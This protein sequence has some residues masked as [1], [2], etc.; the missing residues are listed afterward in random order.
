MLIYKR[1]SRRLP[2]SLIFFNEKLSQEILSLPHRTFGRGHWSHTFHV[3]YI[4]L[5]QNHLRIFDPIRQTRP[6]TYVLTAIASQAK[7]RLLHPARKAYPQPILAPPKV[8]VMPRQ[9]AALHGTVTLARVAQLHRL[10]RDRALRPGRPAIRIDDYA[11]S[12][13]HASHLSIRSAA[14]YRPAG[15]SRRRS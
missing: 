8:R 1:T 15:P 7:S 11:H 3:E 6:Q 9:S 12:M 5:Y 13:L 2:S 10:A 4:E 14:E